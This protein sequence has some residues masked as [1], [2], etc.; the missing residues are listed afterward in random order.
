M[1]I[2]ALMLAAAACLA[3][4]GVS[5][6]QWNGML[7]VSA[8]AASGI[9][10]LGGRLD[11]RITLDAREQPLPETADFIRAVTGL[12]VVVAP[13]LLAKPPLI[14]LTV[15]DMALGN[16]LRWIERT[17]GVHAGYVRGALWFSD[18]PVAGATVTRIYDVRDLRM[19][20]P[21]FPGPELGI[22]QPGGTGSIVI[23]PITPSDKPHYDLDEVQKLIEQFVVAK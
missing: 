22:P 5:V 4:D 20:A 15:K 2:P 18:Q 16:L 12:N 9:D 14:S 21:D 7:V 11:Q 10:R 13:A 3:A 6:S 23:A 8:P 19:I 17:A 1:R